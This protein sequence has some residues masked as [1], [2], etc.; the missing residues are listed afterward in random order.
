MKKKSIPK[1]FPF[2]SNFIHLFIRSGK[3]VYSKANSNNNNNNNKNESNEKVCICQV[4]QWRLFTIIHTNT[5][6]HVYSE[7]TH[8]CTP[9]L[10]E[11]MTT[12]IVLN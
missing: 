3:L 2:E 8:I 4:V 1:K 12:I 6:E 5:S 9:L 7:H 10:A 11:R